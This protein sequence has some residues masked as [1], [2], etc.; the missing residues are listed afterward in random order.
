L[1]KVRRRRSEVKTGKGRKEGQG[2]FF[3]PL[4]SNPLKPLAF[5]SAKMG[6]NVEEGGHLARSNAHG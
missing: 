6:A 1:K 2:F 5:I 3:G 4:H